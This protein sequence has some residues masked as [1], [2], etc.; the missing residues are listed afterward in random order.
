MLSAFTLLVL[1][2][3]QLHF[4]PNRGQAPAEV[5]FQARGSRSRLRVD[6]GGFELAL[7]GGRLRFEPLGGAPL[8]PAG[9]EP[10][11]AVVNEYRGPD[12]ARWR[13]AI[14]TYG[15]VRCSAVWPGVDLV[16]YGSAEGLLEYDLVLAPGA[17]PAAIAFRVAG[18]AAALRAD[19]QLACAL[20][21]GELLLR[22]P[23][24]YQESGGGRSPVAGRFRLSGDRLG[25]EVGAY[26][27]SRPLVIDPVLDFSSYLGGSATD[28]LRGL[29]V[30]ASGA[31]Y[32]TG[33]T[34]S[35]DFPL[36]NPVQGA[37]HGGQDLF[38]SKLAADG[39]TL[40]YSTY[41][42]GFDGRPASDEGWAIAVDQ[43]GAAYVCGDAAQG[44]PTTPGAWS[45]SQ[46]GGGFALKLA[47]SGGSL[48]Y[49]TLIE[50]TSVLALALAVDRNGALYVCGEAGATF[51]TTPGA[52]D[53]SFNGFVDG[54][55]LKL[56]PQGSDVEF[57]TFLGGLD[58]DQPWGIVLE[59]NGA[60]WMCG[61]TVSPDFPVTANAW[62]PSL[63]GFSDGWLARISP[64]GS[65]LAYS[66][67]LGGSGAESA[68][69]LARD[70]AGDLYVTGW[71]ASA[72]F[73]VTPGAF[74]TSYA[75]TNADAFV[76][77]FGQND[78]VLLWS[79][80]LGGNGMDTAEP[81]AVTDSG[82]VWV[83]VR[84]GS[85]DFPL[86]HQALDRSHNGSD[87]VA[88]VRLAANGRS[89][90]YS[91][92]YGGSDL[93]WPTALALDGPE[94][95]V[96]GGITRSTD[97]PTTP[98]AFDRGPNGGDDAFLARFEFVETAFDL[99]VGPL[100]RGTTATLTAIGTLTGEAVYF[101]YSLAGAGSGPCVPALGGLCLD[102][103]APVTPLGSAVTDP[104]GIAIL[105]FP[106]PP[107]APLLRVWFQAAVPRGPG[108]FD[109]IKS[110]VAIGQ[111]VP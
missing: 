99:N 22:A 38:I 83:A 50:G 25:F 63:G 35:S 94:R 97:L 68:F 66:T 42:G 88:L 111:V 100:I 103:E 77:K 40:V 58:I 75:G 70:A 82:E 31:I 15:R 29:A 89:L 9:E 20:P 55:L 19:G 87:D 60:A 67:F 13:E 2:Q 108:G 86:S 110:E 27:H 65:T 76:S 107:N 10:R 18:A 109:S 39:H 61:R 52:Y 28:W 32:V 92:Y 56:N 59:P 93:D 49:S 44:F 85:T 30:D 98:G 105:A 74:Q 51:P 102:I 14:P 101:A 36:Q 73:P 5:L 62:D 71:T 64:D 91:S 106:V 7:D 33:F 1:Q 4:E 45:E 23:V 54:F 37:P 96:I 104:F 11:A 16:L 79:T 57:S 69:E 48:E 8:A 34:Q 41:L 21:G 81:L 53:T 95:V 46:N 26:D 72:D 24:L 90:E 17:D 3:P 47:A 78:G 84:T 43:D 12:P 6:P 80:F